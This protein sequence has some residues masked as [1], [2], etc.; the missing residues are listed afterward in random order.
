MAPV[1]ERSP[2][3]FDPYKANAYSGGKDS[4]WHCIWGREGV[5]IDL[6]HIFVCLFYYE[7]NC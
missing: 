5:S 3:S 2:D 4:V 7:Y 6:V 1:L